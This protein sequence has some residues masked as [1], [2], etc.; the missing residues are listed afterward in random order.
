VTQL[1]KEQAR[2]D[3]FRRALEHLETVAGTPI[4][5]GEMERWLEEVDGAFTQCRA[6]LETRVR[7]SHAPQL[8]SIKRE[9]PEMLRHVELL[10]KEDAQI[11]ETIAALAARADV[12]KPMVR[13]IEPD[14]KRAE[15]ALTELGEQAVQL[16]VRI[17]KQEVA[18]RT[19]LQ[20]AFTR[21][22]GV[23]D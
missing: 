17:R 2:E 12:L 1:E 23:V 20:E 16:V 22:R 5:S 21:D 7:Q 14:E 6:A 15:T 19:W 4:V 18:L 10:Q 3:E 8:V 13:R 9:D 11:L